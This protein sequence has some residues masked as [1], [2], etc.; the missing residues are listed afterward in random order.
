MTEDESKAIQLALSNLIFA[1]ESTLIRIQAYRDAVET[2]APHLRSVVERH[3]QDLKG[4]P[5]RQQY[6]DLRTQAIQAVRD[7]DWPGLSVSTGDL[8]GRANRFLDQEMT[9]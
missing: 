5:L 6:S 7:S 2:E 3:E 8:K 9:K 4:S 1:L